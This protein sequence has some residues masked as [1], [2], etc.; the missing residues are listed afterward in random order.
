MG[1]ISAISVNTSI[2]QGVYPGNSTQ[3][4]GYQFSNGHFIVNNTETGIQAMS[5]GTC[6]QA[7]NL[8]DGLAWVYTPVNGYW[9][10]SSTANPAT[11]TG[12]LS[13]SSLISGAPALYPMCGIYP[14]LSSGVVSTGGGATFNFG[15]KPWVNSSAAPAGFSPWNPT[16]AASSNFL[17]A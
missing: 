11:K 13:I 1:T 8:D 14:L 16:P 5:S 2:N 7:W 12:G 17:F 15:A 10:A 9:N 6:M 4:A 3:S